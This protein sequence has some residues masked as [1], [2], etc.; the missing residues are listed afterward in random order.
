MTDDELC[1][2][3]EGDYLT[4]IDTF[5][6]TPGVDVL[7]VG[8][9]RIRRSAIDDDYLNG[10]F[11]A[12]LEPADA[13]DRIREVMDLFGERGQAFRW[14]IYPSDTPADLDERLAAAS[15]DDTGDAPLMACDLAAIGE[16]EAPPASLE[17][18]E[19]R[20]P[21]DLEAAADFAV[22]STGW[23][24]ERHGPSPFGATFVRLAREHPPRMRLFAGWTNGV[25][26]AV[27]GLFTGS[28]VAGIYAVATEEAMRG[29]G[30]GRA[31]TLAALHAARD[32]GLAVSVL[33][34]S[35]L[36]EGVYR[37][38]GFREVGRVRFRHHDGTRRATARA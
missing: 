17:L 6:E 12:H 16:R 14:A 10:V 36:G 5:A 4:Y 31:L 28:G 37:R 15:F 13:D 23:D 2:L 38:I 32:D 35:D 33:I 19:A 29:R 27:A 34:A 9:A 7:H 11:G 3:A 30:Y 20:D 1:R 21:D 24:A 8:G 26:V 22:R 18:R 25:L